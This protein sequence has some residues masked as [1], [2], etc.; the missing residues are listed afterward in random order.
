MIN[1]KNFKVRDKPYPKLAPNYFKAIF[2]RKEEI[3]SHI[4][5]I[6]WIWLCILEILFGTELLENIIITASVSGCPEEPDLEMEY[7]LPQQLSLHVPAGI[8]TNI[9]HQQLVEL[10]YYKFYLQYLLI[11][12]VSH[13][14][15]DEKRKTIYVER[16]R[17]RLRKSLLYQII[18]FRRVY[19]ATAIALN[20]AV[21]IIVY[22]IT[23]NIT[24]T[25]YLAGTLE[26]IRRL[27]K[28]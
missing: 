4:G 14:I 17:F 26:S 1:T 7:G 12:P 11:L 20:I 2:F 18:A 13:P 9:F 22:F 27:V 8:F 23:E 25:L 3:K 5:R 6:K 19:V 28:I 15:I 24:I 16:V 21:N 10:L